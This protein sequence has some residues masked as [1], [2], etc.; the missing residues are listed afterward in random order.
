[1]ADGMSEP[2]DKAGIVKYLNLGRIRQMITER[3]ASSAGNS[4]QTP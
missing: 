2:P 3:D 4:H 1:M